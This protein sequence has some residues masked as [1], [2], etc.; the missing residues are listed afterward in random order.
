MLRN[1]KD[2]KKNGSVT[3]K[4]GE[5]MSIDEVSTKFNSKEFQETYF[6]YFGYGY[7]TNPDDLIPNVPFVF[8]SFRLM[9]M[10]GLWFILLMS[11]MLFFSIR[12]NIHKLKWLL[13]AALLSLPLAYI[14][15]ETGWIVAE[16]G[17]QPWA[18]QDL[19]P[20]MAAV[21]NIDSGSVIVTFVL[22]AVVFSGLLIAEVKIMLKQ[23][24]IGPKH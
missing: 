17:R 2:A 23:I 13:W 9:V 8:Y 22:F 16:M 11:M 15:G 3:T 1:F 19:L 14:A 12:G 18:I 20:V 24:K 4:D 7:F 21:S 5:T 10:I 6:K